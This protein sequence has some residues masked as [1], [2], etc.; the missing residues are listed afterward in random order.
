MTGNIGSGK[1]LIASKLAK[2][3]HVIVNMDTIQQMISGGE[4]GKYDSNKKDIYQATE[5][6]AIESALKA[7][8]S[9]VV[10]RTNMDKKRRSTFIDVGKKYA[11]EIISINFG[12]GT[13]E[14][15]ERRYKNSK[16]IPEEVWRSVY[17]YMKKSYEPPCMDEGFDSIIE[18]P[19]RFRFHAFDFDGTISKNNFP[20]I[21][22][23]LDSTVEKMNALWEDLSN[24][25]IV[26]SCRSGNYENQ[27]KAFLL[28]NKI[29]FDFINENPVFETYGRKIF[30]HQYYDDRN[31]TMITQST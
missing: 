25:I 7:G 31:A 1:S 24:I 13:Q 4:Y 2:K 28:K 20:E 14:G 22:E 11:K 29:P 17:T 15:L 6:A 3:D 26:W 30:A 9:V 16:G 5:I 21:G 18:A 12:E 19:K 27:M 23:I 10:D 8:L